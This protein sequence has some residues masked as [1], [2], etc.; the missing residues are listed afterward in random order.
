MISP[1]A[2]E[3]SMAQ[4]PPGVPLANFRDLLFFTTPRL[5]PTWPYLPVV[6]RRP[7]KEEELGVL[8]DV[9]GR[10]GP[11]GYDATVFVGNLFLLPDTLEELLALPK[12]VFD[13]PE[14]VFA[15]G[16]RVD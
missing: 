15:A 4:P 6:R 8:C 14:E 12:E 10:D 11:C 1:G 9:R 2:K 13:T 3:L 7:G 5:W 16:W